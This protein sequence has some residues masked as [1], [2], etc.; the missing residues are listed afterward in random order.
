MWLHKFTN[1]LITSIWDIFCIIYL[2]KFFSCI[3]VI[4]INLIYAFPDCIDAFSKQQN[5]FKNKIKIIDISL[6]RNIIQIGSKHLIATDILAG[7]INWRVV[8]AVMGIL[9]NLDRSLLENI[10]KWMCRKVFESGEQFI[11]IIPK[12][13]FK[14]F[15]AVFKLKRI[16]RIWLSNIFFEKCFEFLF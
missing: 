10:V 12:N 3:N 11:L 7:F 5:K 1:E 13:F 16:I 2:S 8:D 9:N 4:W 6:S 14:T 15:L